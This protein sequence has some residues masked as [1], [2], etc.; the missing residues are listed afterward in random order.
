MQNGDLSNNVDF[1]IAFKC[2]DF[3]I[4][5]KE[6]KLTD[7]LLNAFV[8]KA[9]RAEVDPRVR[10]IMEF[11]Y[12]KT[13]YTVD[14]IVENSEYTKDLKEKL[15]DLPFNRI[16]LIDK[17]SQITQRLLIGDLTLY[18][19]DDPYRRSLVNSPYAI[20]LSDIRKYIKPGYN[21]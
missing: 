9:K 12:R 8:G 3:L 6:D 13:T 20:P 1:T 14:L 4:K 5:Y 2:V 15:D 11:I 10:D 18:V 19:D 16:V 7:K 17:L 21:R